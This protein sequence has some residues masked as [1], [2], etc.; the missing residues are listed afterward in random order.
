LEQIQITLSGIKKPEK[1]AIT[2]LPIREKFEI[3]I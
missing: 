3:C 2:K 1:F